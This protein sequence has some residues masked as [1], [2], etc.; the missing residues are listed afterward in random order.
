MILHAEH[1]RFAYRPDRPVLIDVSLSLA[2]GRITVL[3]GPNGSGK[4]TLLK[5]LLGH[6]R[7]QSGT[8]TCDPTPGGVASAT[9]NPRAI[10]IIPPIDLAKLLAYLPQ[11]PAHEPGQTVA[12]VLSAGRTPYL[13]PF[14]TESPRDLQIVRETAALLDLTDLLPRPLEE[15]SGGQR[16]RVFLGRALVQEPQAFLLD[17]PS[18]FLDLRHQARM[19]ELL[20]RLAGERNLAICAASHDLNLS[21]AFADEL[22][23]LHDGAIVAAGPPHDVLRPD[24]LSRVYGIPIERHDRPGK[25]PVVFPDL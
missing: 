1:L 12:E 13:G 2:P 20:R 4:S 25:T 11:T 10:H 5:L 17:E 23:V 14:G 18:T 22:L 19:W 6:L 16:Q 15:L 21:A 24:T 9:P 8:I 3:L 7:P